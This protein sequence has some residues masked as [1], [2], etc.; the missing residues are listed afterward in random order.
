MK[1]A[2]TQSYLRTKVMTASP[3]E[4]RL[5]LI[6]GAIRFAELARKGLAEKDYEASYNGITRTQSILLELMNALRPEHDAALCEKLSALYTFMYTRL[7]KAGS[8]RDPGMI[9]EV[10]DLLRFERET[11]AM[12]LDQLARENHAASGISQTP[13]PEAPLLP[14]DAVSNAAQLVG[15]RVS[16]RG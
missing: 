13:D 3:A 11:W 7:I 10:L 4:L 1:P 2:V 6:D 5:M 14:P 9:D 12:V 15:A 16:V 8:E